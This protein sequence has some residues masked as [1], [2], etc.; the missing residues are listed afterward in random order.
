VIS[1]PRLH[2]TSSASC[3]GEIADF[4]VQSDVCGTKSN[5]CTENDAVHLS[6]LQYCDVTIKGML[7][8][9]CHIER[10]QSTD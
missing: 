3:E 7:E 2:V 1:I 4:V 10:Q 6:Q 8:T 9:C 5:L